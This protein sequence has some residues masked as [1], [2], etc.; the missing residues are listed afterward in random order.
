MRE[1][2]VN[3]FRA[4]YASP[5]VIE[6]QAYGKTVDCVRDWTARTGIS[7]GSAAFARALDFIFIKEQNFVTVRCVG[8][9]LDA[10]CV[11]IPGSDYGKYVEKKPKTIQVDSRVFRLWSA[12]LSEESVL[13]FL[14]R[15]FA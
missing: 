15:L 13:G 8:L 10:N 7:Y 6:S 2:A 11:P 9:R 3:T 12:Y 1:E 5:H 14:G 4:I